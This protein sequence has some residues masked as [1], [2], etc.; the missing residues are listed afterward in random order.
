MA[1]KYGQKIKADLMT[2][3]QNDDLGFLFYKDPAVTG[4]DPL[5]AGEEDYDSLSAMDSG[6]GLAAHEF[7]GAGYSRQALT[8]AGGGTGVVRDDANNQVR[9]VPDD[10]EFSALSA[11][12]AAGTPGVGGVI[13]FTNHTDPDDT[14]KFV[15]NI[16]PYATPQQPNGG[17]FPVNW[18][19]TGAAYMT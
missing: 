1:G 16:I 11:S 17:A 4:Y 19:G 14:T 18:P 9:L 6:G 2:A 8:N 15:V 5:T 10:Y 12:G 3:M 7:D 13:I